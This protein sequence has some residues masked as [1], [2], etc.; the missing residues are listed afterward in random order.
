MS[1]RTAVIPRCTAMKASGNFC[2]GKSLPD[3][4]FPICVKHAADVLHYLNS[5]MPADQ[6]GR[7]ILAVRGMEN[8]RAQRE[9]RKRFTPKTG[10]VYYVRVGDTIKI[11]HSD[12]VPRRIR[13]YPPGSALLAVEPGELALEHQRHYQFRAHRVAGREWYAPAPELMAHIDRVRSGNAAA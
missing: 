6:D 1:D 9:E 5:F 10:Q 8:A 13:Q 3:A 2:D 7:I 11:G 4:P 12:N